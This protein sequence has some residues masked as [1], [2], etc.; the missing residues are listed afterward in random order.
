MAQ[1]LTDHAST[2]SI[3]RAVAALVMAA[4]RGSEDSK[5]AVMDSQFP[6]SALSFA[7]AAADSP[8]CPPIDVAVGLLTAVCAAITADDARP[9]ASKAFM[10]A[11]VCIW[12]DWNGCDSLCSL[13]ALLMLMRIIQG[14]LDYLDKSSGDMPAERCTCAWLCRFWRWTGEE[15][16]FSCLYCR[17]PWM[18]RLPFRLQLHPCKRCVSMMTFVNEYASYQLA[19]LLQCALL[20]VVLKLW[21]LAASRGAGNLTELNLKFVLHQPSVLH[22]LHVNRVTRFLPHVSS[23][24]CVTRFKQIVPV[25]SVGHCSYQTSHHVSNRSPLTRK[26]YIVL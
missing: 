12:A 3:T 6:E 13:T 26:A 18:I 21:Q 1:L 19:Q 16:L 24:L 20:K 2:T 9:P 23:C 14:S 10:N 7:G 11:R 4:V 15:F 8:D 17:G 22:T 5:C 25:D